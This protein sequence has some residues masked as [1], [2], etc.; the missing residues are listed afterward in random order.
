M[1]RLFP[2]CLM[3]ILAATLQVGA[4]PPI[5]K[6]INGEPCFEI[7]KNEYNEKFGVFKTDTIYI[8]LS[9]DIN[10][11]VVSEVYQ[12]DGVSAREIYQRSKV[13][14][15]DFWKDAKSSCM[16]DDGENHILIYNS[17]TTWANNPDGV[18]YSYFSVDF[19]TKI[20]CRDNR[21]KITTYGFKTL[22]G[23]HDLVYNF[24]KVYKYGVKG[25]GFERSSIGRSFRSW[26]ETGDKAKHALSKAISSAN[27]NKDTSEW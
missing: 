4:K 5:I 14:A 17:R 25:N 7:Y 10:D 1:K 22:W 6:N 21:Y 12:L 3:L 24:E 13:A 9:R 19:N 20:E 16:L 15:A 8:P 18:M 11:V 23:T 2:I 27:I 26:K